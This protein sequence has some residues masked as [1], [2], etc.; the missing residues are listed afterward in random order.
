M[1]ICTP[2][3]YLDLY[4]YSLLSIGYDEMPYVTLKYNLKREREEESTL[5]SS[6]IVRIVPD[7]SWWVC[8]QSGSLLP[9]CARASHSPINEGLSHWM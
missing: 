5:R 8:T 6:D 4:V 1:F 9:L 3:Q 7:C 2:Q